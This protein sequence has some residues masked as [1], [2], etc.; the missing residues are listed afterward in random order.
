MDGTD[1]VLVAQTGE[2]LCVFLPFPEVLCLTNLSRLIVKVAIP[3][4]NSWQHSRSHLV[5]AV[6]PDC[7]PMSMDIR[8][9]FDPR[10]R[11]A[12]FFF[13]LGYQLLTVPQIQYG[14]SGRKSWG[15]LTP[16]SLASIFHT[17]IP[18]FFFYSLLYGTQ[19]YLEL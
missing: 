17:T 6:S 3:I 16:P 5:R 7:C 14:W 9:P 11:G 18:Q 4:L 19:K 12:L 8:L 13:R 1:L 2:Q 15:K 10:R